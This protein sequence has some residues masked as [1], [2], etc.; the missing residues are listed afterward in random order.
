MQLPPLQFEADECELNR[1][2]GADQSAAIKD[3]AHCGDK[4]QEVKIMVSLV[5][6]TA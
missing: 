6:H 2:L 3:L 5:G 4:E 1:L